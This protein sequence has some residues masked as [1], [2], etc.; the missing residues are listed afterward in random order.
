MGGKTRFAAMLQNKLHVYFFR[1]TVSL[2]NAQ[3]H[4]LQIMVLSQSPFLLFFLSCISGW[5]VSRAND[6]VLQ[7]R[8]QKPFSQ[9]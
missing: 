7:D 4:S 3:L 6:L 1:F 8:P 2:S 5:Q 9:R